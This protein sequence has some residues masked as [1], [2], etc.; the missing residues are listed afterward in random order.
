MTFDPKNFSTK[1]RDGHQLGHATNVSWKFGDDAPTG[2]GW[3]RSWLLLLL[4]L[5]TTDVIFPTYA[6]WKS[7]ADSDESSEANN[8]I[9]WPLFWR[10]MYLIY[11]NPWNCISWVWFN[12][13]NTQCK[14]YSWKLGHSKV[15]YITWKIKIYHRDV[16]K[17]TSLLNF[18]G[19]YQRINNAHLQQIIYSI[20]GTLAASPTTPNPPLALTCMHTWVSERAFS[21]YGP[22]K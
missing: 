12:S 9:N 2:R 15:I 20:H 4:L 21:N 16:I 18:V 7:F 8:E 19:K 14:K 1:K 6:D 22:Y 13:C 3:N 11:R 17:I 10:F 5:L